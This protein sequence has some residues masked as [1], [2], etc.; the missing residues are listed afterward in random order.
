[1]L[2]KMLIVFINTF[3]SFFF[4]FVL[5]LEGGW[6]NKKLHSNDEILINGNKIT[7][8][9]GNTSFFI[10]RGKKIEFYFQNTYFQ[11]NLHFDKNEIH[12][13]HDGDIWEKMVKTILI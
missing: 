13:I 12:W 7:W 10:L 3:C 4:L 6:K 9:N 1:M 2:C 8:K 5:K 11:G